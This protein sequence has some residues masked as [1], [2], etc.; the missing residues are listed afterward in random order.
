MN[1]AAELG[2]QSYCFRHF[3][4]NAQI[5]RFVREIGLS[6]MEICAVHVNLSAPETWPAVTKAYADEGITLS[7]LGVQG[8]GGN[9]AKERAYFEFARMAGISHISAGLDLNAL[10]E[11]LRVAEML[12]DEF[13]IHLGIHNHGGRDW[14]GS[15]AALKWVLGQT[16]ERIGLCLDTAWALDSGENP[17][18]MAEQFG[19]RLYGIH[20][21]DFAFDRARKPEDVIVGTGNLDLSALAKIITQSQWVKMAVLEY[22]GDEESPSAALT[23]C[24]AAVQAATA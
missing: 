2:V 4:D 17:I 16:S 8:F 9:A 22:E 18:R 6:H 7:S 3:Q 13:D 1:L 20:I 24:V 14:L 11:T 5:A 21:K 12:A 15:A 10:P 19:D 23:Q